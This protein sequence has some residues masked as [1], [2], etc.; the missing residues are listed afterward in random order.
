MLLDI[1]TE[2]LRGEFW[3]VG[4]IAEPSTNETRAAVFETA[5]GENRLRHVNAQARADSAA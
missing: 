1:T 4:T 2:R 3:Y 5:H